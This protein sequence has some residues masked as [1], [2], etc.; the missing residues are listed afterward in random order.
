MS[1]VTVTAAMA[2]AFSNAG[3]ESVQLTGDMEREFV[4]AIHC[5]NAGDESGYW[6]HLRALHAINAPA[7]EREE[8]VPYLVDWGRIFTPI[9]EDCWFSIRS[10]G[11]QMFP[12]YPID[13]F[14]ADF[15]D[16][17]RKWVIECDGKAYHSAAKDAARDQVMEELG[18]TVTRIPGSLLWLPE[19]DERAAHHFIRAMA[20]EVDPVKY[21]RCRPY[22]KADE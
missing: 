8:Y 21:R 6:R 10:L 7:V 2:K 5:R 9:E 18:W 17:W 13:H 1:F 19:E 11:L 3:R 22:P 20:Y 16:P 14:F 4:L 15:A 12:Q